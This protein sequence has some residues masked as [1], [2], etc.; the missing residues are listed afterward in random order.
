MSYCSL[1]ATHLLLAPSSPCFFSPLLLASSAS[2]S[3]VGCVLALC[4]ARPR[5]RHARTL[6]TTQPTTLH[7]LLVH[8]Y[9]KLAA[10]ELPFAICYSITARFLLRLVSSLLS[11]LSLRLIRM[12]WVVSSRSARSVRGGVA[13]KR[14]S[15]LNLPVHVTCSCLL[16]A[17]CS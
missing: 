11:C 6:L 12:L 7:M 14:P 9:L 8:D 17:G 13:R 16:K 4:A 10:D 1:F 5:A 15:L 3:A 2:S